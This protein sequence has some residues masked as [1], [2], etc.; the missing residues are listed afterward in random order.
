MNDMETCQCRGIRFCIFC[1]ES[2]RVRKLLSAEGKLLDPSVVISHQQEEERT[3]SC[4]L[5]LLEESRLRFCIN[6][7]AIFVSSVPLMSCSQH[8]SSLR[9]NVSIL[10]LHV[11]RDFLS[12]DEETYLVKFLDDPSPYPP[13]KESQSGRRVQEYGPKK[14]FKKKKIK[15]TEFVSIPLPFENI[16]DKARGLVERLTEKPYII[17]EV[18]V[19]EYLRRRLS[20]FD[21]HI[22]D[23][24]LWGD[25]IAGINLLEDCFITFVNSEGVCL[26]VFLPR[27]CFFLMSGESRYSWMHA[28]RPE[29]VGNRRISFTI[30]ELSDAFKEENETACCQITDAAKNY[31]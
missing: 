12:D 7:Q 5:T 28:I 17:A 15:T 26:E 8:S 4:S 18:S 2:E 16:L 21:P 31:L 19:L 14:N 29:N 24:W 11:V 3:S 25:R 23:T 30:R 13:W 10:G 6:C 22:D 20:N 9:S 1:K 27:K